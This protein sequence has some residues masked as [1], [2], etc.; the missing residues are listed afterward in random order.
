M[1]P[2]QVHDVAETAP[3]EL[4]Q[5]GEID[6]SSSHPR[7]IV[8]THAEALKA[9]QEVALIRI[10]PR[11]DVAYPECFIGLHGDTNLT[12]IA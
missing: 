11:G 1:L 8:R 3:N 12:G 5:Q 2:V 6:T 10:F 4:R 9:R 7:A